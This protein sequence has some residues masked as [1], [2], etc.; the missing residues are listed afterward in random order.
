MRG[1]YMKTFVDHVERLPAADRTRISELVP[2]T[3]FQEIADSGM[4]GWLPFEQNLILTRA[5]A[6]ALGPRRTHDFFVALMRA[7]FETPL[8]KS[9][10]DAV[11]RLQGRD[12]TVI[13]Q[14][15]SKGFDLMFKDAGTWRVVE[16]E[17]GSASMEVRGL[18]PTALHDRVW[19]ESVSSS[20]TALFSLSD[21]RG[22]TTIRSVEP[23]AGRVVFRLRWE[24]G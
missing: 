20:L 1:R 22:V 6:E 10:V 2:E 13:L 19:L 12:P 17:E 21:V 4:F 23:Q 11:L 8:L 24:K 9:L 18:P 16:C 7:T 15:V 14:W 3:L 5:V